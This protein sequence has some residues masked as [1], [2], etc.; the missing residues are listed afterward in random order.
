MAPYR[1]LV[2][3]TAKQGVA[4]G[5]L[6]RAAPDAERVA[7]ATASSFSS[8]DLATPGV[9]LRPSGTPLHHEARASPAS[10]IHQVS[11]ALSMLA[12]M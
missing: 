8:P 10:R 3:L 2:A 6:L 5:T 7:A 12:G 4:Q 11:N 1:P 9:R